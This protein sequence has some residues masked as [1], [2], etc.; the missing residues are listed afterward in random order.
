MKSAGVADAGTVAGIGAGDETIS[1]GAIVVAVIIRRSD[2]VIVVM[3]K[4][5]AAMDIVGFWNLA[6]A[7][8]SHVGRQQ[9]CSFLHQWPF[10][11]DMNPEGEKQCQ[12][13]ATSEHHQLECGH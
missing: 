8:R 13:Q 9:V 3:T 7:A 4:R 12:K 10:M 6:M 11:A 5:V 2:W 1:A